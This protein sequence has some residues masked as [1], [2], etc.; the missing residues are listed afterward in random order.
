MSV[1]GVE[2]RLTQGRPT[3]PA[4]HP[5]VEDPLTGVAALRFRWAFLP[6][7]QGLEQRPVYNV[8]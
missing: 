2:A 6:D 3:E 7:A 4:R 8:S 1:D 5:R